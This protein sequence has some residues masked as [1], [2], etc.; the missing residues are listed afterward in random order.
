MKVKPNQPT[1]RYREGMTGRW[2][3]I[4]LRLHIATQLLAGYLS[5]PNALDVPNYPEFLE[6]A[7]MLIEEHNR[8][9]EV[10]DE[11]PST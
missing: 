8:T 5:N 7:D 2:G 10:P 4:P 9:S 1:E 11:K 6:A 3:G